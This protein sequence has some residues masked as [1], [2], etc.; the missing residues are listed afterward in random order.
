MIQWLGAQYRPV[1]GHPYALHLRAGARWLGDRIDR[2]ARKHKK[3][4]AVVFSLILH[5]LFV[6]F[7]LIRQ[8]AGLASGGGFNGQGMAP[9]D[10]MAVTLVSSEDFE[11]MAMAV[12]APTEDKPEDQLETLQVDQVTDA[13]LALAVTQVMPQLASVANN[14]TPLAPD[15]SDAGGQAGSPGDAGAGT[16][17]DDLWG[18]IAPCWNRLADSHTLPVTLEVSFDSQGNIASPPV[19][20]RADADQNDPQAER[21][22]TIA[23]QAL[24]QC[25]AY[26]MAENRA[27]VKVN[28]PKP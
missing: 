26:A 15:D 11:R 12:K 21:S 3:L 28:F 27:G 10:G 18:A 13:P 7:L 25:G 1:L 9:G 2:H 20:D 23:M 17:G 16:A 6:L 14:D 4:V 19:I 22:E 24:A 8:P 5:V